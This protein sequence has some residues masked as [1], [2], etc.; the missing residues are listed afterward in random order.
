MLC[1]Q[2]DAQEA[3]REHGQKSWSEIIKGLFHTLEHRVPYMNWGGLAWSCC[4]WGW[5]GSVGGEEL[6]G[7]L[8]FLGFYSL[9]SLPF[10]LLLW[11]QLY[12]YYYYIIILFY[13]YYYNTLFQSLNSS[14]LYPRLLLYSASH[15]YPTRRGRGRDLASGYLVACGQLELNH[16]SDK[17]KC[18]QKAPANLTFLWASDLASPER[19][20]DFLLSA[21]QV[22]FIFQEKRNNPRLPL[23]GGA[24]SIFISHLRL[25]FPYT[26]P[27]SP[28][29][30]QIH[31]LLLACI[32]TLKTGS[33]TSSQLCCACI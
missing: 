1:Q 5:D 28:I 18:F 31:Q 14:Y 22:C 7:R 25:C 29:F 13:Y 2:A 32:K 30:F 26:Y 11:L 33:F 20:I 9:L 8:V 21:A 12:Y 16:D 19:A 3:G 24:A 27:P 23:L 17:T 10:S 6:C 15:P 4:A